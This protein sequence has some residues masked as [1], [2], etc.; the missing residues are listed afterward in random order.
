[1]GALRTMD[2]PLERE[3][4]EPSKFDDPTRIRLQTTSGQGEN[5]EPTSLHNRAMRREES[6]L[7]LSSTESRRHQQLTLVKWMLLR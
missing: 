5:E 2:Q 6:V 7:T 1:M 4:K 3:R